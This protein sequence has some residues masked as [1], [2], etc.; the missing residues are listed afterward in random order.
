MNK[1]TY[2]K[3]AVALCLIALLT[4]GVMVGCS[5]TE[6]AA[7]S[8]T[9]PAA[10]APETVAIPVQIYQVTPESITS[11]LRFS[12]DVSAS[13][14]VD[15]LPE[16]S[17]KV[18]N[19]YVGIGDR[20][21]KDQ[22]LLDIDPSRPG[23][24]YNL[25]QVKAI[26]DGTITAF[27][28]VVGVTV[29]PTMSLGKISD[30]EN[31]EIAFNVVERYVSQIHV[32]QKAEITFTAYPGETFAA[33]VTKVS[34]TL[35]TGSRTLKVT[36]TLDKPDDRIIIGMYAR[37]QVFTEH[38][39]NCVV[40]PYGAVLISD[41]RSYVFVA[42]DRKNPAVAERRSV[43]LGIRTGNVVEVL[44]GLRMGDKVIVKGQNLLADGSAVNVAS[45]IEEIR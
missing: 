45:T 5:K 29:A 33:T 11:Y 23:T 32:G 9:A 25:S 44:E 14:N 40:V 27:I 15:I 35:D 16:L 42:N 37:I 10:A 43:T 38:K 21:V 18:A 2:C 20:V 8:T 17:G 22:V 26:K 28:P 1:T 3:S 41:R 39:E 31:L 7:K 12:G 19:V 24:T 6:T 36:C 30:T 4:I 34:P 13:V